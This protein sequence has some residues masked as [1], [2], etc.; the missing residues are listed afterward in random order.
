MRKLNLLDQSLRFYT[1]ALALA[2]RNYDLPALDP[3]LQSLSTL[4]I[5]LD[6][7]E[8][9]ASLYA[10]AVSVLDAHRHSAGFGGQTEVES[11]WLTLLLRQGEAAL[12]LNNLELA[13][14][15]FRRG[16]EGKLDDM[17]EEECLLRLGLAE[18]LIDGKRFSEA[19]A[20]LDR[21]SSL[22]ASG[23]FEAHLWRAGLLRGVASRGMGDLDT[24]VPAFDRAIEVLEHHREG[25]GAFDL[26][27]LFGCHR[28]D[29]YREIVALLALSMHDTRKAMAYADRAKSL[30]IPVPHDR[31]AARQASVT[32]A[33]AIPLRNTLA[34]DYFFAGDE[35]LAFVS[36][37]DAPHL[38]PLGATRAAV[39][40]DVRRFLDSTRPGGD[41]RTFDALARS[42]HHQ[43]I[44]PVLDDAGRENVG[45][46]VILPDGP[47]YRLPF[48]GLKDAGGRY[49]L[50]TYPLSYA[51]SRSVLQRCLSLD[52]PDVTSR[53]RSVLLLDGTAN[54]AGARRELA[55]IA[56]LYGTTHAALAG[57][58]DMASLAGRAADAE[59]L[60]FAGHGK[61]KDGNPVLELSAGPNPVW[62]DSREISTWRF[63]RNGL[64]TLAG[65]ET[66]AGPIEEGYAPWGLVPAFL[67]AG[68]PALVV[69]LLPV[70]DAATEEMTDR[71][72]KL[73]AK[74]SISR[75]SALQ[76][77][78]LALL[79]SSRRA[80]RPDPALWLPYVLVGDPR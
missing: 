26:R 2:Y 32:A 21:A 34:V 11:N 38:V 53:D 16:L 50:E 72:Y 6:R 12:E 37:G 43:L 4:M 74:G 65:C 25:P 61:M 54:L 29:P 9:A 58:Q 15:A 39:E 45:A 3:L 60:H 64:V 33:E 1:R 66:G 63:R 36:A 49:L 17:R 79:A 77:A 10:E 57:A 76:Q 19:G 56:A 69:S 13:E 41:L 28:M 44:E 71:F 31:A 47:L 23:N 73:L 22:A 62:L 51:P 7:P 59:I 46:L 30:S 42:L 5:Q 80:G 20:E 55:Q 40:S 18:A 24:A 68:A 67:N 14:S 52:R 70:D 35:L 48:A 78:Q 75:A 27:G 8:D